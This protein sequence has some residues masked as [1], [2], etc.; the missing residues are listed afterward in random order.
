MTFEVAEFKQRPVVCVVIRQPDDLY[1]SQCIN[2]GCRPL[3]SE[4]LKPRCWCRV[5]FEVAIF[6]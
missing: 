3:V 6:E 4:C 5:G 1:V 2:D